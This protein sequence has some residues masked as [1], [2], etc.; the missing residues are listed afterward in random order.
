MISANSNTLPVLKHLRHNVQ[1]QLAVD[2]NAYYDGIYAGGMC[3]PLMAGV[4]GD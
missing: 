4:R 3:W 1:L 2:V